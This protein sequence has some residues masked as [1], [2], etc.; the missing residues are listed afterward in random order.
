VRE[1]RVLTRG[2]P[3]DPALDAALSA[4]V[5]RRVAAGE[6]PETLRIA[7]TGPVV[8][9]GKRDRLAAGFPA[10][11]AAAR[12]HGMGAVLRLGGGRAA[13]FH[14]GTLELAHAAPDADP[15]SGIERRFAEMAGAIAGALRRLG[16]QAEVGEVPGEYC[17]GRFSVGV[18]GTSKLAGIG[19]RVIAGGSHTG[20]A[21]VVDD[22]ERVRQVLLAVYRALGLDWDPT[23]AGAVSLHAPV[24]LE[25]VSAALLDEYSTSRRLV[26]AEPDSTTLELARRLAPEHVLS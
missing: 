20:A 25:S 17:P 2:F 4:A 23:T 9:F 10:A 8:A 22:A 3:E 1:L 5:M 12:G 21:I 6:L 24:D 15:R 16:V 19:Q 18:G 13:V 26:H 7:G 14:E 11:L